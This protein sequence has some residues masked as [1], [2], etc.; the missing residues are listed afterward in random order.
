MNH[1]ISR[2]EAMIILKKMLSN[3]SLI[4][5]SISVAVV[6][7]EYAKKINENV[8]EFYITGLLH[9]ADYEKY[10]DEH[11]NVIVNKLKDLK[12][13]KIS[14]AISAHYSKW[15]N[16]CKNNLDKFLLACDE[17]TGFIVACTKVRPKGISELKSKSVLKSLKK[18]S[19]AA[20]VDRNEI[21]HGCELINIELKDH[22]D[23]IID[24]LRK[25]TELLELK[26]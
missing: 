17:I 8:D 13:D 7:K 18:K 6:M 20:S 2:D 16:E 10:P 12:N 24:V 11:P 26:T 19:F 1:V 15:G 5:H 21:Y 9:D 25:N 22:I 3:K 4:I 23:F 14:Y